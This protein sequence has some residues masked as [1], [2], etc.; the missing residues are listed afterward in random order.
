MNVGVELKGVSGGVE[1]RRGACVGIEIEGPWAERNDQ[2]P[3][4]KVLKDRRSQRRR[5][6]TGT[7]VN[8]SERVPRVGGRHHSAE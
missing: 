7:G 8:E 4:S 2:T 6:R 5:G 3:G 1:R